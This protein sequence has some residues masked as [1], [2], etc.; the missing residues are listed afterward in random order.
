ML[1][2][3]GID[4][5]RF[6]ACLGPGTPSFFQF[7]PSGMG[8]SVLCLIHRGVLEA[9][10]LSRFTGSQLDRHFASSLTHIWFRSC[11]DKTLDLRLRVDAG[12]PVKTF[13]AG[14]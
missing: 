3:G 5:A 6:G 8:V 2:A 12:T 11:L 4:L 9:H 1:R 14:L 7:P 13:G 10:D